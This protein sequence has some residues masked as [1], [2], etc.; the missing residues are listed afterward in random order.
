[1]TQVKSHCTRIFPALIIFAFLFGCAE[2]KS[3]VLLSAEISML[4]NRHDLHYSGDSLMSIVYTTFIT[5]SE[6]D[7]AQID[8]VIRRDVDSLL[9]NDNGSIS[10]WRVHSRHS[11]EGKIHRKFYFNSDNYLSKITRFSE[12]AEYTTDSVSYDH[13]ARKAYYH[14]LINKEFEEMEYDRDANIT[15]ITKRRRG[16]G[17]EQVISTIYNYFNSSRS[18]Y[19]INLEDDAQLFGCFHRTAVSLFWN[20]GKRPQFH[21][22]NNVQAAK[23][24]RN[25]E[26]SNALFEYQLRDGL[27]IAR[28]GG[29]GV[30]FYKY[31]ARN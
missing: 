9:Y 12:N 21:S 1:M 15:S 11:R 5:H 6:T 23:L 29:Y 10:L 30:V 17:S 3:K 26:E 31:A 16:P 14:D 4:G 8:T 19:L 24:V 20:G 22:V 27:P 28:Y 2:E 25:K 7:T 13:T 18:P